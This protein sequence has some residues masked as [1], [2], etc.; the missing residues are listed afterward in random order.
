MNLPSGHFECPL[1]LV[2]EFRYAPCSEA[3][4]TIDTSEESMRSQ[5]VAPLLL[6]ISLLGCAT[7]GTLAPTATLPSQRAISAT[8][9]EAN[10]YTPQSTSTPTRTATPIRTPSATRTPTPTPVMLSNFWIYAATWDHEVYAIEAQTG[11]IAS[12]FPVGAFYNQ[13]RSYSERLLAVSADGSRL[14]V[15]DVDPDRNG[16]ATDSVGVVVID[17]VSHEVVHLF[18][19]PVNE[20]ATWGHLALSPDGTL[21]YLLGSQNQGG[22]V[23]K[24]RIVALKAVTGEV[25]RAYDLEPSPT[26]APEPVYERNI[27]TVGQIALDP[28]GQ[29]LYLGYGGPYAGMSVVDL[30]TGE[31]SPHNPD[32]PRAGPIPT[33]GGQVIGGPADSIY[34]LNGDGSSVL[35]VD[36]E[37]NQVARELPTESTGGLLPHFFI[38]MVS[39]PDEDW[40]YLLGT[41]TYGGGLNR[42]DLATEEVQVLSRGSACGYRLAISPEGRYLVAAATE[43]MARLAGSSI[44]IIDANTGEVVRRFHLPGI[45]DLAVVPMSPA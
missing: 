24:F 35:V 36:P 4:G 19:L 26:A 43:S 3:S 34:A 7:P 29:A 17:A 1:V 32:H 28:T 25:V 41:C 30:S 9:P 31:L 10:T 37:T 21:L 22:G 39:S 13:R 20:A 33:G 11:Q 42:L 27:D 40:L 44:L 8:P 15:A 12:T 5:G 23:F 18:T 14:Y 16:D 2:T 6:F 38:E 45:L